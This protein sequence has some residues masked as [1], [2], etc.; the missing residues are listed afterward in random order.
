MSGDFGVPY[1]KILSYDHTL[2]LQAKPQCQNKYNP[3]LTDR[4]SSCEG[5]DGNLDG[6]GGDLDAE[7]RLSQKKQPNL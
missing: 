4:S 5:D 3:E 2:F 7:D 6:V 1:R